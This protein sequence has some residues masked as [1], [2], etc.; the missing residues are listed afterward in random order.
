MHLPLPTSLLWLD[1]ARAYHGGNLHKDLL[2][3]DLWDHLWQATLSARPRD[4][5]SWARDAEAQ[6]CS[7][8]SGLWLPEISV[9]PNSGNGIQLQAAHIYFGQMS[10]FLCCC[11]RVLT[12]RLATCPIARCHVRLQNA[13]WAGP[14]ES[15]QAKGQRDKETAL[16]GEA[17]NCEKTFHDV[18]RISLLP[19]SRGVELRLHWDEMFRLRGWKWGR[20]VKWGELS[21]ARSK[22]GLPRQKTTS[23]PVIWRHRLSLTCSFNVPCLKMMS[24]RLTSFVFRF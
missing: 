18:D 8:V 6:V 11:R 3:T 21:A 4:P 24:V 15:R 23:R 10:L 7:T 1:A 9:S 14:P 13:A 12:D 16:L 20:K 5:G 2:S 22:W 17:G 19:M